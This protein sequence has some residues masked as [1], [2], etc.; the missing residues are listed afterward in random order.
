MPAAFALACMFL[1]GWNRGKMALVNNMLKWLT[2]IFTVNIFV[3]FDK[4]LISGI[5]LGKT[6][7]EN[8][9]FTFI[10][11]RIFVELIET[12]YVTG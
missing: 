10:N 8:Q 9:A 5:G 2:K 4:F 11:Q 3:F 6:F 1:T 7:K 12:E